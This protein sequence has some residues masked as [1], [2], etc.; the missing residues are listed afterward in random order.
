MVEPE[1]TIPVNQLPD[2]AGHEQIDLQAICAEARR[3]GRSLL[4]DLPLEQ[5]LLWVRDRAYR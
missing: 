1:A 5:A 2:R 3:Y 4:L